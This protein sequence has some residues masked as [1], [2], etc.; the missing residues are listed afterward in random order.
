MNTNDR[1]ALE[2]GR[3]LVR[4]LVAEAQLEQA[5]IEIEN[6]KSKL[7][8]TDPETTKEEE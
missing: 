3:A 8:D 4:A 1:F 5:L 2:L 6:L 7:E